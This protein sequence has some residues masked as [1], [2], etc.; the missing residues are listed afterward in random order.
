[1]APMSAEPTIDPSLFDE[2][3]YA[4]D[5]IE[6]I[7]HECPR[8][9]ATGPDERRAHAII[10]DEFTA[11]GISTELHAFTWNQSLYQNLALHFG[12]AFAGSLI[13]SR[14][15]LLAFGLHALAAGS[16]AAD[17]ARSAFVLRKL[18]PFGESQN[19]LARI[20]ARG[21]GEPRLRVVFLAHTDAAYTGVMFRPEFLERFVTKETSPLYK[22]LR[23]TTGAVL[24]LALLDLA[25]LAGLRSRP[26]SLLRAVL[27]I[28]PLLGFALNLDVVL[29]DHIV[30]GAADDL[31]GIAG[32]LLLARR[33]RGRVPDDIEVI[34]CATGCEEAGLGGAHC[35]ARDKA[36]EWE[37]SRTVV[38]GL[39]GLANG[40]LAWFQEGEIFPLPIAPWLREVLR[41][42]AASDARFADVRGFEIPVGG[43]DAVP[44]S[45]AGYDAVTLGC[46]DR[47]R[48]VPRHYHV[49]SD[50][51]ENLEVESIAPCVDFAERLFNTV[52]ARR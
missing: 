36:S 11:L 1:M 37:R 9:V 3:R 10:R 7:V 32:L 20:P 39:D 25:E 19:V 14:A 8:R 22:S 16:Y 23:V 34:F 50:T 12:A 51:P 38:I 2:T 29:R 28:P 44:F 4:R 24:G 48:G 40:S 27:S 43:T 49:P 35:L 13:A 52:L 46:V 47:S 18:F 15:P 26:V 17:S 30:P 6:R 21:G 42:T 31:S 45:A 33:L 5:L 41:D